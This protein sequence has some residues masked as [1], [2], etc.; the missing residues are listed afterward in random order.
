MK[1]TNN[2]TDEVFEFN[3]EVGKRILIKN[4]KDLL[5]PPSKFKTTLRWE[6]VTDKKVATAAKKKEE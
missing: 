2:K 6:K 3:D 5:R 1:L 4:K